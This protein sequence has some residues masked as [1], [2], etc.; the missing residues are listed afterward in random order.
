[1]TSV[2]PA[3]LADPVS[4]FQLVARRAALHRAGE[5]DGVMGTT[6]IAPTTGGTLLRNGHLILTVDRRFGGGR[7]GRADFIYPLFVN[8][9]SAANPGCPDATSGRDVASRASVRVSHADWSV[10]T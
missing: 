10:Q 3:G 5:L 9:L 8:P 1:M 6:H 2:H 4:Q 7:I